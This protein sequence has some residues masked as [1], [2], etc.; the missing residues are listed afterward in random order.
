MQDISD[1]LIV[2]LDVP[3]LEE[4]ERFVK[5]LS[6][7]VRYFKIG[8][9]LF[10]A[11]GP[12]AVRMVARHGGKAFLDL[13][14]YDIPNTVFQAVSVSAGVACEID[15]GPH[16]AAGSSGPSGIQEV[17]RQVIAPVFMITVHIKGGKKMLQRAAMA[18]QEKAQEF[19]IIKPYIVGVTVLTSDPPTEQTLEVVLDRAGQ[20]KEAGLD[21]VVCSAHE[22]KVL[23]EKFG[24]DFI[25]VNPGIRPKDYPADDQKRTATAQEALAAGA[26][27]IVVGRPI[28][29]A[30]DP[31]A[32]VSKLI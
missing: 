12:D 10:S 21:G 24:R 26:N 15:F 28:L 2:A 23:R 8:I 32:A 29:Q 17:L 18:A 7:E 9:Q 30:K 19:N 16:V 22:T 3:T 14:F 5:I 1:K 11:Y 13:K 27:F 25:I 4:A 31:L 6:P 20:A